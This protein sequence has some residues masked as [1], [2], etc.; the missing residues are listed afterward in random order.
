MMTGLT[1]SNSHSDEEKV[2]RL[3][4]ITTRREYLTLVAKYKA[5]TRRIL[6]FDKPD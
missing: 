1:N 6:L 2:A 4:P 5:P 3:R